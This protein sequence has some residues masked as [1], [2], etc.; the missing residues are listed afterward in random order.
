MKKCVTPE[1]TVDGENV[2]I[3]SVTSGATI[4]YTDDNTD[5]ATSETKKTYTETFSI[6]T[7][8]KI[9]AIAIKTEFANSDEASYSSVQCKK[10]TIVLNKENGLTTITPHVD[11]PDA[12]IYYTTD[13][14]DP[15]IN[16]TIYTEPFTLPLEATDIKAI[17]SSSDGSD[18]SEVEEYTLEIGSSYN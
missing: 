9:R 1:I 2:T 5:P 16:S 3:T 7:A 11:N 12:N 6:G 10:P 14:S 15:D 4:Y 17:A 18:A 13:G 8:K